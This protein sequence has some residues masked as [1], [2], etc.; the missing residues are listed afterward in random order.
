[1]INEVLSPTKPQI[2]FVVAEEIEPPYRVLIHNDDVTTMEFVVQVLTEIFEL[3]YET[4]EQVML[5]AHYTGIAVVGTYPRSDAERR[6][7]KAHLNAQLA[8]F[9]LKFT[10]EPEG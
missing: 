5:T 8:G 3:S 1:M 4:A 2:E 9:P 6:I 10:M 7:E